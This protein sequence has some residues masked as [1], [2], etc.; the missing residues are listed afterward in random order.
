MV[1]FLDSP[2]VSCARRLF[3][4]NHDSDDVA[5]TPLRQKPWS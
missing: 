3:L 4:L 2:K 5:L 1:F